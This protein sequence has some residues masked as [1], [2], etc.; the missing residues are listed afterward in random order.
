MLQEGARYGVGP[1]R[2]SGGEWS[3]DVLTGVV[4]VSVTIGISVGAFRLHFNLS[5]IG[6]LYLL[7]VVFVALRWGFMQATVISVT[8]VV[9][10]NYLFIPPIFE[11]Q[12]ADPEN[13]VA[14][15]TFE[16]TA[17]LVSGLSSKVRMHAAQLEVERARMAKLYELSRAIMLIDGHRSASGQVAALIEEIVGIQAADL[18]VV[19]EGGPPLAVARSGVQGRS[20]YEV[21]CDGD[22]RDDLGQRTSSRLL[23][24]GSEAVGAMVLSG[25]EPDSLLADAVASL[26]AVAFERARALQKENLAEA[27][28]NTERLRT[29]VLDGLAHGF[30]TPLTA[31]QTASSGLLAIEPELTATQ[32]ELVSIIDEQAIALDRLTTRLLQTAALEVRDV[33]LRRT[34]VPVQT[35][36]ENALMEQEEAARIRVNVAPWKDPVDVEVDTQ[37]VTLALVQLIDNA[38]KYC[39]D[40]CSIDVAVTQDPVK[41]TIEVSNKGVSIELDEQELIFERFYRGSESVHGPSGTGLGLSI[42][43]KTAEAHGGRAWVECQGGTTRFFL[44]MESLQRSEQ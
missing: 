18:W 16:T 13:W 39:I 23:R 30:K 10:M 9:C 40:G 4:G 42:V 37:M 36:L 26:A 19:Y 21:Y 1:H 29:A 6:S 8:A 5:T 28:R 17:L 24:V 34:R 22:D 11:L 15:V 35:L 25:W 32:S 38:L 33:G 12:V 2:L 31:I 14:V 20:A 41:T 43:R 7:L 27:E 44:T 3:R